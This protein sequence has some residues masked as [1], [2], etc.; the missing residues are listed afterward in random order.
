MTVAIVLFPGDDENTLRPFA[1]TFGDADIVNADD[2][3]ASDYTHVMC[4]AHS[5]S[6]DFLAKLG[7]MWDV[8]P[9]TDVISIIDQNT[10]ER[11]V[12]AGSAIAQ[13]TS[14][15]VR[16]L[17]SVR[18]KR[19]LHNNDDLRFSKVVVGGG[20][21]LGSKENFDLV[22][23]LAKTMNAA[24]G[25]TRAAVDAGYIGN[26][27][28][29]GQTGKTITPQ[30]YMALGIS[31]ALQHVGAIRGAETV[32]AINTDPNAPIFK[33][34]TYGLVADVFEVIPELTKKLSA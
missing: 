12:Y 1:E 4:T 7:A 5:L 15:D 19:V 6:R 9:I 28:Q 18:T 2:V 31:G 8:Q 23:A 33:H 25:A 30:L 10:F 11:P 27:T 13:I 26:E 29:I 34:A 14:N 24:V 17:I 22:H 32:I 16:K 20:R 3:A 21:A